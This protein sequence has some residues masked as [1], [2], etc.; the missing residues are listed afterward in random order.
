MAK[1]KEAGADSRPAPAYV[2][3]ASA[4][5]A[6]KSAEME[7]GEMILTAAVR[8]SMDAKKELEREQKK[9]KEEERNQESREKRDT[10][11]LSKQSRW[12]GIDGKALAE[13][14]MKWEL[15][16]TEEQWERF[17]NWLPQQGQDLEKQLKEL[18]ELYMILLEAILTHTTG[19]EQAAQKE[20]LDAVLAEKL[21]LL[22][23][24]DLKELMK[25]LE[26]LGQ[27][28]T[29]N[30]IKADLYKKTTG[31]GVSPRA[32]GEFF[33]RGRMSASGN[34]RF[35]MPEAES[36]GSSR[37]AASQTVGSAQRAGVSIDTGVLYQ[38]AGKGNV[39][40][41]Q[42]FSAQ[43]N[44]EERQM[45]QRNAVLSG[46]RGGA[47]EGGAAASG[48]SAS[49]TGKEL[50]RANSF[51]AHLNGGGNLLKNAGITA[52]NEEVVGLL[53]AMTSIKGQM[54]A[55]TSGRESAMRI[56][57]KSAVN[58]FVDYYLT[59]KGIYKI[60]HQ[61]T[62]A[63]ENTRNVQK[64]VEEGLE[65]AYR[66]FLEKKA[67]EL[68]Q[69]QAAYSRQAGFFQASLKNQSLEED[70]R[71]GLLLL[72][73]NWRDFLRSIGEE[74]RK[75]AF[76][77]LQKYSL[78]GELLKPGGRQRDK[79]EKPKE[80]KRERFMVAQAVCLAALAAVYIFYR[81]F[82]G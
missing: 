32:A 59:E 81:L 41:N 58:Q 76:L 40:I 1:V 13:A 30:Y 6:A 53:A 7:A 69:R 66:Q 29:L 73:K 4:R 49:Y 77:N 39:Q 26:E 34:S 71:K 67:S 21:N 82:F 44:S 57:V 19:E 36:S 47:D 75:A 55:E 18:S 52:N 17:L 70:L 2:A 72:E 64:A 45:T 74:E 15:E 80:E 68:Y 56:P 78:W 35:F 46:G 51:A 24:M 62:S 12:F 42:A 5:A 25:F 23:D 60:Y 65:H 3:E 9:E 22:L 33:S 31:E 11:E 79:E 61:T 38:R 50:E 10:S 27:K 54:Y 28:D 63:Y 16:L 48:R 20:R 14:E 43:K 8:Q 37:S